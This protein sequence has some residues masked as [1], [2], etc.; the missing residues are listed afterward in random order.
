MLDYQPTDILPNRKAQSGR[1]SIDAKLIVLLQD[2]SRNTGYAWPSNFWLSAKI[3]V[4]PRT[5]QNS[6]GRLVAKGKIRIEYPKGESRRLIPIWGEEITPAVNNFFTPSNTERE[7]E[8]EQHKTV[9]CFPVSPPKTQSPKPTYLL[10]DDGT[11]TPK[12][13]QWRKPTQIPTQIPTPPPPKPELSPLVQK[14]VTEGVSESVAK[15]LVAKTPE[16]IDPQIIAMAAK[17]I[18]PD[19]PGAYLAKA[20]RE[21]YSAPPATTRPIKSLEVD[22]QAIS[23]ARTRSAIRIQEDAH[24]RAVEAWT[25]ALSPAELSA[26]NARLLQENPELKSEGPTVQRLALIPLR[27][28]AARTAL[29][30]PQTLRTSA[31]S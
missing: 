9:C 20:I 5:I 6:L 27:Q 25:K 31:D 26:L 7:K 19:N 24:S 22:Q 2:L 12:W 30:I 28:S 15:Q 8:K 18:A 21:N 1:K 4:D 23:D 17:K 11:I 10:V 3:G 16:R 29:G 13:D 14:L